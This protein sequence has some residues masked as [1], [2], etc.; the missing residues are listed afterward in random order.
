MT[1]FEQSWRDWSPCSRL[2]NSV[3]WFML[4][5]PQKIRWPRPDF[6]TCSQDFFES[7][8]I[9]QE[10]R[11]YVTVPASWNSNGDRCCLLSCHRFSYIY[12][13]RKKIFFWWKTKSRPWL[14]WLSGLSIGL[15]T[16][17]LWVRFPV[18]ARAWITA[19]V[20]SRG[21]MRGNHTLMFLSLFLFPFPSV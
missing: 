15:R 10:H 3:Q 6:L 7:I 2:D 19:Q 13:V 18:K 8:L 20:T 11:I 12:H 16:K 1:G 21:R 9:S 14:V 4:L 17:G 5:K